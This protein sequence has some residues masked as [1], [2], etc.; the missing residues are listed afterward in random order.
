MNLPEGILTIEELEK[1]IRQN[2]QPKRAKKP[3][4]KAK[5]AFPLDVLPP[6]L[7]ELVKGAET[8][9]GTPPDFLAAACLLAAAI[10][11]GNT[12]Q[13]EIKRAVLQR[14][15]FY[16]VLVGNPNS[17]KSGALKF[18][19]RPITQR[20]GDNYDEYK[21]QQAE[22]EAI[23]DMSKKERQAEG[24]TEIPPPPVY[25]RSLVSDITPEALAT[26]HQDNTRGIGVHRDELAGWV[27]DFNRYHQG[28]ETEMWLSAWNGDPMVVD[29]KT[30]GPIRIPNTN[31]SVAGTIQPAV[32]EE[33]ANGGRALNGF[34]DRLLFVW[35]DGLEKPLWTDDEINL[36]LL[37]AY[38][39]A[40]SRLLD[41]TFDAEN[42]AH[43]LRMEPE[44]RK[45]LFKF[46]N[47]ENKPLCDTAE[48]ELL[49]GIYGKFDIHAQRLVI[50]L[51]LLW[52]A[53]QG[54]GDVPQLVEAQTVERAIKAAEYFRAQSLKV[55]NRL[56]NSNPFDDLPADK[57]KVYEALP[58]EFKKKDGE[59]IAEK[60]GMPARTFRHWLKT[61]KG[62]L[63]ESPRY[64]VWA[65][66]Y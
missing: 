66:L 60:K 39:D 23:K 33:L 21:A 4:R 42:K 1:D 40:I 24:I 44:A 27:K 16:L 9:L 47:E 63:F 22:F 20:D 48:N 61:G 31:I 38:Q 59:V 53:Y 65:K 34:I 29:R 51:H 49:G 41:L 36:P 3:P 37:E 14:A 62:S 30:S 11:A 28:G 50:A 57:R 19:L 55:F 54:K 2:T 25:R 46:F 5:D 64:G 32:I 12:H 35:P 13:L 26:V 15:I 7:E 8:A 45:R 43:T 18:A 56:H 58:E 10:A 17:N 52:W 6:K